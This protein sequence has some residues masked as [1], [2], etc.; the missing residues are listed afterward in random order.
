MTDDDKRDYWQEIHLDLKT[1]RK[2]NLFTKYDICWVQTGFA[3]SFAFFTR[4]KIQQKNDGKLM[5]LFEIREI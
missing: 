5:G 4:T 2:P 1:F 3:N